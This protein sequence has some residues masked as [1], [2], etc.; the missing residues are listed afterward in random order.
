[1]PM[2]SLLKDYFPLSKI[3]IIIAF[4]VPLGLGLNN[5][6]DILF[7]D[8]SP[9]KRIINKNIKVNVGS[10]F[11]VVEINEKQQRKK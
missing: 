5:Y 1:M 9:I 2:F 3:A 11:V 7:S 4:L 10:D 8:K 6:S